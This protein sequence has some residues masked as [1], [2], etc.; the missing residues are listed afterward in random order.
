MALAGHGH[1][2]SA[3]PRQQPGRGTFFWL[4]TLAFGVAL[5]FLLGQSTN[6][7]GGSSSSSGGGGGGGGRSRNRSRTLIGGDEHSWAAPAA[8][9]ASD[10]GLPLLK[11]VAWAAHDVLASQVKTDLWLKRD[12]AVYILPPMKTLRRDAKSFLRKLM[13][14]LLEHPR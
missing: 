3:R 8:V 12:L 10:G 4:L 2:S 1:A 7:E 11:G 5:G 9:A 13:P 14:G 6:F